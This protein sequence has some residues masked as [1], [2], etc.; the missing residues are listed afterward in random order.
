MTLKGELTE[1]PLSDLIEMTALGGKTGRL[2]ISSADGTLVGT[3]EFSSGRLVDAAC[4]ELVAERAFYA[5]LSVEAGTFEFDGDAPVGGGE[6]LL[7]ARTLL[8]EGMRRLDIVERLRRR[9]PA[10][11]LVRFVGGEAEDEAETSVLAYLGPGSRRLGDIVAG[12]LVGG[13]RDEYDA[14]QAVQRLAGRGVV[15]VEVPGE[16]AWAGE[17]PQPE[18]ER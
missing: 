11:A 3:L 2:L 9:L 6:E 17:G 15:R 13:D 8:M 1:L 16:P 7:P 5:L 12:V 18:L 4:R 14:L 10:P